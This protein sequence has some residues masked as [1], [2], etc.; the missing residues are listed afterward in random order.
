MNDT[1]ALLPHTAKQPAAPARGRGWALAG[2]IFVLACALVGGYVL[3]AWAATGSRTEEAVLEGPLT[4]V[5]VTGGTTDIEVRPAAAGQPATLAA[6]LTDRD[7]QATWTHRLRDGRLEVVG[8]CARRWIANFCSVDL[9]LTLPEGTALRLATATGDVLIDGMGEVQA[10]TSTGDITLRSVTGP[11]RATTSTGDISAEALD[12]DQ[13]TVRTSTGDI[14]LDHRVPPAGVDA[15]ASTGDITLRLP[16]DGTAYRVDASTSTGDVVTDVAQDPASQR[17]IRA[18]TST[19][20][21]TV[22]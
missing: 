11:L 7:G 4:S 3:Y 13:A 20:D 15:R 1:P 8:D 18:E 6:R 16:T 22:R 21:V 2:L 10:T 9:T 17:T 19:G 14:R 5:E 12:V